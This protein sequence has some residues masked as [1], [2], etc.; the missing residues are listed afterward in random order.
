MQTAFRAAGALLA[1]F[2][3]AGCS[4]T[5]IVGQ[6]R[7]YGG[8]LDRKVTRHLDTRESFDTGALA[9]AK[10]LCDGYMQEAQRVAVMDGIAAAEDE[11][12][13]AIACYENRRPPIVGIKTYREE[14]RNALE[15]PAAAEQPP[16]GPE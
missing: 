5:E 14:L 6:A 12:E 4:A 9:A 11:Y 1:L 3:L 7:T 2:L 16:V 10:A 15:S 13:A 8:Y